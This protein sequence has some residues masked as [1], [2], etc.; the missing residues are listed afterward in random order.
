MVLFRL[1]HIQQ[2][3]IIRTWN[4]VIISLKI[5]ALCAPASR[6]TQIFSEKLKNISTLGGCLES[7][8]HATVANILF[9]EISKKQK[10]YLWINETIR[11][12]EEEPPNKYKMKVYLFVNRKFLSH[13]SKTFQ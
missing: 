3:Y 2:G 7:V 5:N 9:N 13:D 4:F 11:N 8:Q 10:K 12:E 1:G 6:H